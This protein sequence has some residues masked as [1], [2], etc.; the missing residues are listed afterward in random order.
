MQ[1]ISKNLKNYIQ[2]EKVPKIWKIA[3]KYKKVIVS[4]IKFKKVP[5]SKKCEYSKKILKVHK[6][7]KNT[8]NLKNANNQKI[9][10]KRTKMRKVPKM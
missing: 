1:K 9:P 2:S 10:L 6:I 8:N 5:K 7:F 3:K 4:T